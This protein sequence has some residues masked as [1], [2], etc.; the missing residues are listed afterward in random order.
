M[1]VLTP[2]GRQLINM[3]I[4]RGFVFSIVS[5][6]TAARYAVDRS[7]LQTPIMLDGPSGEQTRATE[8]CTIALLQEKAVGGKMVMYAYVVDR[9]EEYYEAPD[10][11]L[12]RWQMQ[13][14]EDDDGYLQ[15]LRVAQPGDRPHYE[16]TLES[17]TLNPERVSRST[18]KFLVCKGRQ[19]T[20]TV[21]LTAARAWNMPVS[22]ISADA[23]TRL[24]LTEQPNDWCQ[25]RP[26]S[27]AGRQEDGFL[28]KI[29]SVL[30]IA[31]PGYPT[32]R[33]PRE[34]SFRRPDV[35]TGTRDW[36][37]VERFLCSMK[38]DRNAEFR[39]TRKHHIRIVLRGGERWYLN[40][41]VSE[42]AR[43]SKITSMAAAKL[44]RGSVH[45]KRMHLRD[46]NWKEVSIT[47][48]VVNTMKELLEGEDFHPGVLKPHMV[49][50][51][52]DERCIQRMMLTGWMGKADLLKGW[53]SQGKKR[54]QPTREA[55]GREA[56]EQVYFKHLKV[57]TE[58]R[59]LRISALFDR[60]VPDTTVGYGAATILGLKG[61]RACH[62]VT[63][64]DGKKEMSY[65]WYN[66]LLL[67]MGG[68]TKQVKASGVLSTARIKNG[69]KNGEVYGDPPGEATGPTRE[70][71][72]VDLIIGRDNMDCKPEDIPGCRGWPEGGCL[73]KGTGN[74]GDYARMEA[75]GSNRRN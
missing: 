67:D 60:S 6:K 5:Q 65:A 37:A 52:G 75:G 49:L 15:W 56:G 10:R 46:V 26:C 7:K 14:G 66:V 4:G 70:W 63:T 48:D 11:G 50:T 23:A 17:V 21:W 12:Q 61:G 29:A 69:G 72:C 39:E 44:G 16:L 33:R 2:D 20:E 71:E 38:P 24:G 32:T 1:G 43:R 34:L 22:R 13:L 9:L 73:M 45:D 30:E 42:T 74:P 19:M 35:V 58:G 55:R 27:T 51:P 41:L 62:R 18:W 8:L 25:V 68:H 54:G 64:V 40:L 36:E 47:V 31:P 53:A 59:T 28:A 57:R 3:G